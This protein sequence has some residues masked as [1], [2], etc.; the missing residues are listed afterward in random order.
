[1]AK[2]RIGI[3]GGTFDP[4]H[5][6]HIHMALSAMQGA[7]LDRV[8]VLPTGNPPHKIGITPA[9]DRWRMVCCA[10]ALHDGLT[11]CR[12]EIDREGVIY[13]VDTLSILHQDY[14]KA[15]LFYL[16]GTD[17]LMELHTWRNF[18]QVLSLCTF[19]ICPR[20]TSV[21][22]KVLADEQR[23]L[24]ALGGRFVALDVDVVDV[25][26]TELRQA[27]R[28]GQATPHCSVPVREYCKVRGLYGLSPRVPQGDKW[29][30]RLFA[31]LNQHRFMHSLAVAHTARQLAIAH[32]LDPA[33]AEAAGLLHDC[34]KCLPLSAMQQLCRDHQLTV[35]PDILQSGALL[36]SVAGACQAQDVYGI[37]DPELLSAITNH[38]SGRPGMSKLDMVIWLADKIEPT[39]ASYPLLDKVRM[40]AGFSLEKALLTSLE[41]SANYLR[42]SGKTVHPLTLQTIAW[43]KTLPETK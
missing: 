22:P 34:A 13:T 17:T 12:A 5:E 41:G 23:R 14:P 35:D 10:C 42:S 9:E 11:P 21:S 8:L 7:H 43:L 29:L 36:H 2:E 15:E 6:G 37:T 25:S 3:L 20:P 1:M 31:D 27:L 18:E 19:V 16:I 32:H 39:R 28:D 30:D 4:I 26:S 33:K 24:I 38:T 40:L